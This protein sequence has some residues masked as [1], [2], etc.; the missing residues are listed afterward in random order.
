MSVAV[1]VVPRLVLVAVLGIL[2]LVA[3]TVAG[4][5]L[6]V[7]RLP[8]LILVMGVV[9]CIRRRSR[10]CRR[11]NRRERCC[12]FSGLLRVASVRV[13]VVVASVVAGLCSLLWL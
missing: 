5:G 6:L 8:L 13:V 3:V 1:P 2:V 7:V 9:V 11:Y 10:R 4:L 12:R